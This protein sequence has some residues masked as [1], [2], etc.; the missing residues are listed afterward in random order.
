VL[1]AAQSVGALAN[2]NPW[3]VSDTQGPGAVAWTLSVQ[4]V[5]DAGDG[6]PFYGPY[7][8]NGTPSNYADDSGEADIF[9]PIPEISTPVL[10]AGV[11]VVP[12]GF[13]SPQ[14]V[15][16]GV[17]I[18]VAQTQAPGVAGDGYFIISFPRPMVARVLPTVSPSTTY[19]GTWLVTL[20]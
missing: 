18:G 13:T 20:V 15:N 5:D 4:L 1:G 16:G 19:R 11:A 2:V 6:L 7:N 8:D 10:G 9:L 3:G 14:V 12:P 17:N